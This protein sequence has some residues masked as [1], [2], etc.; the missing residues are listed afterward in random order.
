MLVLIVS[1]KFKCATFIDTL[2]K[3]CVIRVHQ[4]HYLHSITG[5]LI[6]EFSTVKKSIFDHQM[7]ISLAFRSTQASL[8]YF[9]ET[10]FLEDANKMC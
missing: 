10:L 3:L 1:P 7:K 6:T 9:G 5:L 2:Y 8:S 4:S